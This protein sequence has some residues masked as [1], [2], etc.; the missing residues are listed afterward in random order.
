MQDRKVIKPQRLAKIRHHGCRR[1]SCPWMPL[2]AVSQQTS[3][4]RS[5]LPYQP[6]TVTDCQTVVASFSTWARV[7]RRA[8][9][10]R[11]RPL[12]P[13]G[14]AGLAQTERHPGA[15][16][17]RRSTRDAPAWPGLPARQRRCRRPARSRALAASGT[18]TRPPGVSCRSG[19]CIAGC[20]RGSC[21]WMGAS[22]VR[23]G[24]A[25]TRLA[26]VGHGW[27]SKYT[28]GAALLRLM[29]CATPRDLLIP[30]G[31]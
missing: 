23:N 19:L 9:F 7:G 10:L 28:A 13:A 24:S 1:P 21:A 16:G 8:P 31:G 2:A 20:A 3:R 17:S 6:V 5:V 18:P 30:I 11:G 4:R 26:W 15:D 29:F 14:G 22:T 12:V 27:R 25:H